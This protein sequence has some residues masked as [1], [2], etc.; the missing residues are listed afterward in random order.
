MPTYVCL[1]WNSQLFSTLTHWSYPQWKY[2]LHT[3]SV[4]KI[5][6]KE[7]QIVDP[8]GTYV[9]SVEEVLFWKY[10]EFVPVILCN[11]KKLKRTQILILTASSI[12]NAQCILM[13]TADEKFRIY[14]TIYL[15]FVS[16]ILHNYKKLKRA[17]LF[18]FT[19]SSFLN[20]QYIL[21]PTMEKVAEKQRTVPIA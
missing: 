16:L 6:T 1:R 5:S 11:Y 19:T 4:Y 9:I 10:L 17:K 21:V 15:E 18:I 12:L 2:I 13:I 8:S 14:Y 3:L 20:A 7:H